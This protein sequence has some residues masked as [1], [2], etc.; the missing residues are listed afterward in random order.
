MELEKDINDGL[1]LSPPTE[2]EDTQNEED[3]LFQ[4]AL[5]AV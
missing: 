4:A 3:R 2:D 1:W 5:G